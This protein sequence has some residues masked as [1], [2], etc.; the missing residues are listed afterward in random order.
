[1]RGKRDPLVGVRLRPALLAVLDAEVRRRP[2]GPRAFDD[3]GSRSRVIVD[4]LCAYLNV[5]RWGNP[6]GRPR[7]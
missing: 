7:V 4:A 6:T 5:D 2:F 1:M 3:A